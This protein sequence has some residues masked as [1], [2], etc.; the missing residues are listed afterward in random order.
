MLPSRLGLREMDPFLGAYQYDDGL[1]R[2]MSLT[3]HIT[4]ASLTRIGP[5]GGKICAASMGVREDELVDAKLRKM[6]TKN[7]AD[8]AEA[9]ASMDVI[10]PTASGLSTAG[11]DTATAG[12]AGG[13]EEAPDDGA[14]AG[15]AGKAAD[16]GAG[17]GDGDGDGMDASA[18]GQGKWQLPHPATPYYPFHR[19]KFHTMGNIWSFTVG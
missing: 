8:A 9:E 5:A 14:G 4:P 19:G 18:G 6:H 10:T 7:R 11:T 13:M 16:E 2:W 1:K 15:G 12:S 17:D 3:G